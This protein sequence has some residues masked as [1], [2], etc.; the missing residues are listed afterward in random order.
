LNRRVS[1]DRPACCIW[2]QEAA[3]DDAV[4]HTAVCGLVTRTRPA[5][6]GRMRTFVSIAQAPVWGMGPPAIDHEASGAALAH[7][8][9]PA[10]P[11][12]NPRTLKPSS[13]SCSRMRAIPTSAFFSRQDDATSPDLTRSSR[14]SVTA[15]GSKQASTFRMEYSRPGVLDRHRTPEWP[16]ARPAGARRGS[17]SRVHCKTGLKLHRRDARPSAYTRGQEGGPTQVRRRICLRRP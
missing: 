9:D 11:R 6:R 4:A 13:R 15:Q 3:D 17:K 16:L 10:N 8:V 12:T 14:E 2:W 7:G 5:G 1:W